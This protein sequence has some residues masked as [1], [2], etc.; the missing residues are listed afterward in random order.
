MQY[1][2]YSFPSSKSALKSLSNVSKSFSSHTNPRQ[3]YI[4]EFLIIGIERINTD[5]EPF[6][7]PFSS[8]SITASN[9]QAL[10]TFA[11]FEEC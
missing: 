6:I 10:F 4:S 5:A 8:L 7:S 11:H 9:F 1:A 3:Q 2:L